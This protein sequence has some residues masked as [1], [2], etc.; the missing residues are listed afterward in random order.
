M[1]GKWPQRQSVGAA[2]Q[3]A[4]S[5]N[6]LTLFDEIPNDKAYTAEAQPPD[7][8]IFLADDLGSAQAGPIA[9]SSGAVTPT[10]DSIARNGIN[11]RSGYGAPVCV[12][13]RTQLLTG[14]YQYRNSVAGRA[15]GQQGN[16]PQP[17]GS[18]KTIAEMLKPLGY[19]TGIVG[20]WH[21]GWSA[22]QKP[23]AQGFDYSYVWQGLTPHYVGADNRAKMS[24]YEN[25]VQ[26]V[27]T[28][29]VTDRIADKAI[30]FVA[31][32][33]ATTPLFLYVPW[34]APHDPLESVTL[35][36]RI[37]QND[38]AMA[39]VMKALRPNTV[40]FYMGDNGRAD[41]R[42]KPFNRALKNHSGSQTKPDSS[43]LW[44]KMWPTRRPAVPSMTQPRPLRW[45]PS[46][47]PSH[48]NSATALPYR[49]SSQA[50][51]AMKRISPSSPLN[52][53]NPGSTRSIASWSQRSISAIRHRPWNGSARAAT[54]FRPI[55]P[56]PPA[57]SAGG[58]GC[59]Q[60]RRA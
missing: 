33:P 9:R 52:A 49:T 24:P 39:R 14:L 16:G 36:G 19:R 35:A 34:L 51:T 47:T 15:G 55:S 10:I 57:A 58:R 28:G 38:A 11:F 1:A 41:G 4:I 2:I 5:E 54:F 21:L 23:N 37:G 42:N 40:I 48:E 53:M 56:T 17:P 18:I 43:P 3:S 46:S 59:R 25:G 27:N 50:C 44:K 12:Q 26:K 31:G 7:V 13:A 22:A 20:K 30:A 45:S 8:V 32:T 60:W 6:R 29:L